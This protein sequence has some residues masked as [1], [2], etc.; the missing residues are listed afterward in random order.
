MPNTWPMSAPDSR[1][2]TRIG[3]ADPELWAGIFRLNR[4]PLLAALQVLKGSM[5][6]LER[7]LAHDQA[8]DL[9]AML[10]AAAKRRPE[11]WL[12]P[13]PPNASLLT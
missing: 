6:R 12:T 1:D 11:P 4:T 5:D 13:R 3:A 2:F 10:A 9:N 8:D 7:A